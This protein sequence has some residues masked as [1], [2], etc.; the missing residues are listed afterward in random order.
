MQIDRMMNHLNE[1]VRLKGDIIDFRVNKGTTFIHLARKAASCGITAYGIDT[2]EGLPSPGPFDRNKNNTIPHPKGKFAVSKV[3]VENNIKRQVVDE[4]SYRILQGKVPEVFEELP[5]TEYSF[6][7]L[8]LKR[9]E[10]TVDAL[11]YLWENMLYG[12]TIYVDDYDP[13]ESGMGSLAVKEFIKS[14]EDETSTS[15]MMLVN[16]VRENA[17]AIKCL[18]VD[19]KPDDWCD[20][21]LQRP[22]SIAMVLKTG[23]DTYDYKYVNN[24]AD[25]IKE[26]V[27][28]PHEIVCLTDDSTNFSTSVDRVVRL[29]NNWPK[30][31]SKI[32]LFNPD[33]FGD[34]QVFFFDLDTFVVGNIDN[35]L[36]YNGE[37]CGLRDFYHLYSMGSGL[38][39]WHGP[40]T[41]TIYEKFLQDSKNI[42]RKYANEG[43][44]AFIDRFRPG[45]DF[46]QDIFPNQIVSY[47]RHCLIDNKEILPK[48]TNI[49]CFHGRPRP[50]DL[51]TPMRRFW[52]HK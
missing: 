33:T 6:A 15:R 11:N 32:E 13:T 1:A 28:L 2:F 45:Y 30:W 12:G 40:K 42:M 52:K 19:K 43:D 8:D 7:V 41:A 4:S 48:Q 22:I 5:N 31:W 47:K 21:V 26:N 10:P 3:V 51:R 17:I 39:S 38:M 49:V 44:Q 18:R 24:L 25:A 20:D 14:K 29:K 35:I 16:G 36:K 34:N 46:F 27:T 37:F 9:Y 23:G 50:H